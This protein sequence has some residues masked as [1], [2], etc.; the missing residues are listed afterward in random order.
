MSCYDFDRLNDAQKEAVLT[1]E[2]PVLIIAGPGTGKTFTL[3]KRIAYL[4]IEKGIKPSEIM[5]VTFTEK[6]GKELLT[7]ISNE[8]TKYELNLNLNEMYIG[9][10]HSVC[11]RLLKEYSEYVDNDNKYRIL[12]AFEQAYLVCKNIE[13][14]NCLN[15]Y[16][17][18][19]TSRGIWRQSLE[20]CR[21]VNQMMEE[22]VDIAAMEADADEDMRFLA[23]FVKRYQELLERNGVMDFSSIQIKTYDM[24]TKF[25]ELLAKIRNN[26]RY[27]MV[28]E[29]QDTNYIQ[30]QLVLL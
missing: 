12:D 13:D 8:F 28:D 18:H 27:I 16:S 29:Y 9:T 5:V 21:Y 26:I 3:V 1:T 25:P 30:E 15:G 17:R 14:F 22:L 23:K 19:I 11:L 10:F 24:M 4:I 2:G 6:A 7:R 20:I